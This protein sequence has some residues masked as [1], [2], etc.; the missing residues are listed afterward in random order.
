[1][2]REC[3]KTIGKLPEESERLIILVITG[4]RTEAQSFRR[5][6]GIGSSS[7][8][9]LGREFKRSD[10]S[11]S[12]AGKRIGSDEWVIGGVRPAGEGSES[13]LAAC[14]SRRDCSVKRRDE[15][16]SEKNEQKVSAMEG[17]GMELGSGDDDL[18]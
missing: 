13:V 4:T 2:T 5:E 17:D 8:C 3:L 7:H 18:R 10:T 1:M 12:E 6:V 15:I 14:E 9:L 11:A 16:L